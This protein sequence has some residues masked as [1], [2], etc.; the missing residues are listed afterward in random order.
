M[1]AGWYTILSIKSGYYRGYH[2]A[3]A[4]GDQA[5]Q[6]NSLS[7]RLAV[8]EM[9]IILRWPPTNPVTA[10]DL[11][12]HLYIPII[13]ID[14]SRNDVCDGAAGRTDKCHLSYL[15]SQQNA[16]NYTGVSTKDYHNYTDIV[17]SGD[18]VTLDR[19]AKEA[20]GFEVMTISKVRSGVYSYSVKNFE[21]RARDIDESQSTYFK[22]SRARVKV[23]YNDG[24]KVHRKKF[25]VPNDNGTLW[26]VFT[27]DKDAS[28]PFTKV[29]KMEIDKTNGTAV[30]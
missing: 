4:C 21:D 22:K 14:S 23:F 7:A 11:D 18:W 17:S 3:Y 8:G 9:R 30:Y 29:K 5:N 6:N 28:A 27:F 1:D 2:N 25:H 13:P 19:D 26:T 10:I 16:V 24:S 12:S 20:P 15:T